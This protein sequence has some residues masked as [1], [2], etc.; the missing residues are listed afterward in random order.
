MG[1]PPGRRGHPRLM[2]GDQD[3]D[4]QEE[5]RTGTVGEE[6]GEHA[7]QEMTE[8]VARLRRQAARMHEGLPPDDQ[9]ECSW[10]PG[11]R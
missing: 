3:G 6:A 9:Q 8:V 2:D 4:G 7:A 10:S 5:P 11:S 1:L